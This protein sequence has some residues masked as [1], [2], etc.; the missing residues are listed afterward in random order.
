MMFTGRGKQ[1]TIFFGETDHYKHQA[2]YTAIIEMLRREG[3][4]GATAMRQDEAFT[5]GDTAENTL[6]VSSKLQHGNCL[7]QY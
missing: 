5:L 7:H 6:S 4:S 2:L 1:L 3:C